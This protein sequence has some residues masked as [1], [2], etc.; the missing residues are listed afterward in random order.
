M[1]KLIITLIFVA[2]VFSN[3]ASR[4]IQEAVITS[5]AAEN[6]YLKMQSGATASFGTSYY[7]S[8]SIQRFELLRS[9][10]L[11]IENLDANIKIIPWNRDYGEL[12]VMKVSESP[13]ELEKVIVWL[14]VSN[15]ISLGTCCSEAHADAL[16]SVILK[17]PQDVYAQVME[18]KNKDLNKDRTYYFVR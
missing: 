7:R 11:N 3:L 2:A 18:L 15:G 5:D 17:L 16:V 8:N 14:D 10:E 12:E 13:E 4:P 1:K 9:S 6:P